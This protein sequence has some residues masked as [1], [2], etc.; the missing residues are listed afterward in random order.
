MQMRGW[1]VVLCLF[2]VSSSIVWA[3]DEQVFVEVYPKMSVTLPGK[4]VQVK[5]TLRAEPYEPNTAI[6]LEI[7]DLGFDGGPVDRSEI[8]L[9]GAKSKKT[10]PDRWRYLFSGENLFI[11]Y[12]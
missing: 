8:P 12:L 1:I 6:V 4:S 3:A 5:V 7:W 11:V 9:D 10:Q 2:L